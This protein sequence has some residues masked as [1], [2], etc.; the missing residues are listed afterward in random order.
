[1]SSAKRFWSTPSDSG[2]T[3]PHPVAPP[4]LHRRKPSTTGSPHRPVI[5]IYCSRPLQIVFVLVVAGIG[6]TLLVTASRNPVQHGRTVKEPSWLTDNFLDTLIPC[7]HGLPLPLS[8][9]SAYVFPT[10]KST[11]AH[12]AL[13]YRALHPVSQVLSKRL[14]KKE[15][16]GLPRSCLE[17]AIAGLPCPPGSAQPTPPQLDVVW[18]WANGTDPLYAL[19]PSPPPLT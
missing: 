15:S 9:N 5:Y 4:R 1:M 11:N 6:F 10:S 7:E 8:N 14:P 2:S 17:N 12:L 18:T 19:L 13:N 16:L 3:L